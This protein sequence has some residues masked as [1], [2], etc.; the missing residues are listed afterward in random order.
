MSPRNGDTPRGKK[1]PTWGDNVVVADFG[2][3]RRRELAAGQTT[4]QVPR[5]E[6]E[7]WAAATLMEALAQQADSGRLARGREYYRA[8]KILGVELQTNVISGLVAGS[9]LEPF[10]VSIRLRSLGKRQLAFV[11]Q[12]LLMDASHV[13]SLVKGSAPGVDVAAILLRKDHLATTTCT[14]P[15]RS[16]ACKHVVAVMYAVSAQLSRDPLQVLRLRGIDPV[17]LLQQLGHSDAPSEP[18]PLRAVETA[19][20]EAED[21]PEIV[22]AAAFWGENSEP[23]SW[24]PFSEEWGMEQG[25]TE[26][27]MAALRTVSWTG[28][29]QLYIRHELERCYETLTEI[30]LAFDN[31]PWSRDTLSRADAR[32][33]HHD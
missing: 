9:Q 20:S 30:D 24:E 10:D 7:T 17:P 3:R 16:T 2:A 22:D 21:V 31:V 8:G 1:H 25:D 32:N 26:A 13:R 6:T 28:V 19:R 29:D 18:R 4:P 15:D 33:G 14:C 5:Q 23:I 11:E 12:E 27:M